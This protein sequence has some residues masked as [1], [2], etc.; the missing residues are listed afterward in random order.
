MTDKG[1]RFDNNINTIDMAA[2]CGKVLHYLAE[3]IRPS[4]AAR[5]RMEEYRGTCRRLIRTMDDQQTHLLGFISTDAPQFALQARELLILKLVAAS[6]LQEDV[7]RAQSLGTEEG[8]QQSE[9]TRETLRVVLNQILAQHYDL[10][11]PIA[12]RFWVKINSKVYEGP[13]YAPPPQDDLL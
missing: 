12:I 6:R 1:H 11:D 8:H 5:G 10:V 2:H 13:A 4:S 3:G 7:C 9:E